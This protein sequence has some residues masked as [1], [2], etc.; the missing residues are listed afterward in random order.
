MKLL[1]LILLVSAAPFTAVEA[2]GGIRGYTTEVA[3]ALGAFFAFFSDLFATT[4]SSSSSQMDKSSPYVSN[5]LGCP[6]EVDCGSC[7][8]FTGNGTV[9]C[10]DLCVYTNQCYAGAS[11]YANFASQCVALLDASQ[12]P[13]QGFEV[14]CTKI[15]APVICADLCIYPNQCIATGSGF[16][17]SQCRPEYDSKNYK[18]LDQNTTFAEDSA[19][20]VC[21]TMAGD[22]VCPMNYDPVLCDDVCQYTNRCA[23]EASGYNYDQSCVRVGA[24]SGENPV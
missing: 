1:Y 9:L 2:A 21:P 24:V 7:S 12:C 11:G 10:E 5:G 4:S 16:T 23:A 20:P 19:A 18:Q 3:D 17:E 8:T 6:T 15:Y 22:L 13:K 14:I